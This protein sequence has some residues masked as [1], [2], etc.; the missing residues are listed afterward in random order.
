MSSS[1]SSTQTP[2]PAAKR[3]RIDAANAVLR[4]PFRSPMINRP[5]PSATSPDTPAP[6]PGPAATPARQ[7]TT[8]AAFSTPTP[9][10]APSTRQRPQPPLFTKSTPRAAGAVT[11]YSNPK[12]V[13]LGGEGDGEEDPAIVEQALKITRQARPGQSVDAELKEATAKWRAAGRAA[14]EDLFELVK[15]RVDGMGA[16]ERRG[17]SGW[18]DDDD[19]GRG[20]ARG[21]KGRERDE[22]E[23]GED[24]VEEGGGGL[25]KYERGGSWEGAK[26]LRDE[27]HECGLDDEDLAQG[28]TMSMML[29]KLGIE[30]GL[31]G[32]D[33]RE[34][35]WKD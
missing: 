19:F 32:W 24:E 33:V 10:K 14:A 31:L 26:S 29:M 2:G 30:P 20:D 8:A 12:K 7:T 17:R 9:S 23:G 3:R 28:F 11:P 6:G 16:E 35:K 15:G 18:G 34:N 1:S 4:K 27:C 13:V 22:R 21:G 25:G 5:P